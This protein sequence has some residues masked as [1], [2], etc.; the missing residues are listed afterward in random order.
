MIKGITSTLA[1]P[2]AQD[3][4]QR[5]EDISATAELANA[6]DLLDKL[7][8]QLAQVSVILTEYV[9]GNDEP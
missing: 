8:Q 4:A 6:N 2:T 7:E 3:T 9:S 5:L 1:I